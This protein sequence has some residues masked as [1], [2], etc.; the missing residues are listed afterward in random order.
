MSS[1]VCAGI[2]QLYQ[3][4][5]TADFTFLVPLAKDSEEV[6]V[7]LAHKLILSL[8]SDVFKA[9]FYGDLPK[10]DVVIVPDTTSGT[11]RTFLKFVYTGKLEVDYEDAFDLLYLAKKY[12]TMDLLAAIASYLEQNTNG[13][14]ILFALSHG[15]L[16]QNELLNKYVFLL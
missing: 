12:Q 3:D 11:F 7:V 6:E 5:R 15:I 10:E 14:N 2:A 13:A 16:L 9:M 4:E 8:A 1:S